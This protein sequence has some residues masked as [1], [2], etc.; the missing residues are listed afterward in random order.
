MS[1]L[2]DIFT[3]KHV[4]LETT[5]TEVPLEVT[6]KVKSNVIELN[7]DTTGLI[8]EVDETNA[9]ALDDAV[10][11]EVEEIVKRNTDRKIVIKT[12]SNGVPVKQTPPEGVD[13]ERLR[14]RNLGYN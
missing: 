2:S 8:G 3:H 4:P 12:Q 10:N 11:K 6:P 7:E 13:L 9:K 14:R 5:N 1:I